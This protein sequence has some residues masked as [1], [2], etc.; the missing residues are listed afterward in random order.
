MKKRLAYLMACSLLASPLQATLTEA[1]IKADLKADLEVTLNLD[2]PVSNYEKMELKATLLSEDN[3]VVATMPIN[4]KT[5]RIDKTED[6]IVFEDIPLGNYKV[7]LSGKGYKTYTSDLIELMTTQKHL[8][9][10]AGKNTF[11]VGDLNQDTKINQNDLNG[12]EAVDIEDLAQLYW[13]QNAVGEEKIY[14]T[15]LI[16]ANVLDASKVEE[17]IESINDGHVTIDGQISHLFD[18]NEATAQELSSDVPITEENPIKIPI[19]F[20]HETTVSQITLT[21]PV[22]E[23]PSAGFVVYTDENEQEERQPFNSIETYQSAR[24][25]TVHQVVKINLGRQVPVQKL[26]IE[27]TQT[28]SQTGLLAAI[29]K[30]EFLED[31]VEQAVNQEQGYIK[32]LSGKSLDE[33]AALSWNQAANVTGYKVQYGTEPGKYKETSYTSTN[34]IEIKGLE[35][36]TDYYFV[37]Q[38][39]NGDWAGPMSSEIMVTPQPQNKP[40]AP[41]EVNVGSF[42]KALKVSSRLGKEATSANVYYKKVTDR[43]Y[44][45]IEGFKSGA[46]I[47][48][49]ENDVAYTVYVTA[50]NEAGESG[51]SQVLKAT[52]IAEEIVVPEIPTVGRL[53]ASHITNIELL[54]SRNIADKFYPEGFDVNYL[55][56]GDY[57]T[58]WTANTYQRA[59]GV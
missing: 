23:A 22:G 16:L 36:F 7:R 11:T 40:S 18:G 42:D 10:H 30:I 43:E 13:S 29:S 35:N 47:K 57:N 15:N 4:S 2:Y 53:D 55:I 25:R 6:Y 5:A 9:V 39:I 45:K 58:H 59:R 8:V 31:V 28:N 44:T 27:V 52:P 49:L 54:D 34:S 33:G 46:L 14:N 56:D 38:A 41:I 19:H 1:G 3:K 48:N 50:V 37:V 20:N 21:A 24:T 17:A 12:D 51:P 26:T 32:G